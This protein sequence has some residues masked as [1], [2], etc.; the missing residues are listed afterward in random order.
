MKFSS[1]LSGAVASVMLAGSLLAGPAKVMIPAGA[2]GGWDG[3]GR[4]LIDAMQ[5][6]G[7]LPDG[8]NFTNKGG[9]AGTIG[10]VDF[11]KDSGN[12]DALLITG[13]VM[14]GGIVTNK[15]PVNLDKTTPL[16]RLTTEFEVIAVPAN[17]PHKNIKDL[18]EAFKKDPGKTAIGGGS[19]GGTDHILLGLI[20]K[21]SGVA[22][23]KINY[24][25]FAGGG[26][27]MPALAGG[28]VVAAISGVGEFKP[29]ADAGLIRIL[30]VSSDARLPL[31]KDV[32]TLKESGINI[33]L[34]NWR[35]VV[36]APGM[37]DAAKKAWIEKIDK[38]HKS[39]EWKEALTKNGWEDAFLAGD[40]Y[41]NFLKSETTRLTGIL[42]DLG[43]GK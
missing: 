4:A 15:S 23:D 10:L 26:E 27:A 3:T 28:K 33:T 35:G 34:G 39:K 20:A 19:A 9:A 21:E 29:H 22:V 42:L 13:M 16:A 36:G 11:L 5:K 43:L 7:N 37:S 41:G 24:I 32:P 14:V 30:A 2:G 38:T 31:I 18:V 8:A 40:D 6:S 1:F 12:D 17:S 25:P